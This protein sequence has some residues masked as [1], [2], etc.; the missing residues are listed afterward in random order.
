MNFL[1]CAAVAALGILSSGCATQVEGTTQSV[2]V[3]TTPQEGAQCTL[4]NSQGTW[5][6]TSPGSVVVHKTKTDLNITCQKDG[7]LPGHIVAPSHFGAT[8]AANVAGGIPGV[9]VG[10]VVDA[11]SGA[12][13]SY[14]NLITVPLGAPADAN[15]VPPSSAISAYPVHLHCTAPETDGVFV[16]DGPQGY[17]TATITFALNGGGGAGAID[18]AP[19]R[20][21]VCKLNAVSPAVLASASFSIDHASSWTGADLQRHVQIV[22]LPPDAARTFTFTVKAM[23]KAPGKLVLNF[24][25]VYR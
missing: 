2:S 19:G 11:A 16:A 6:V 3:T 24:P 20:D 21:G 23:D 12:N 14:D 17:A 25:V 15:G 4:T 22:E 8:T 10:G 7:Y 18:V 9:V 1:R 5:F 13:Y